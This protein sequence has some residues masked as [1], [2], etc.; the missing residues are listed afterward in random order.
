MLDKKN[1]SINS[2]CS[3]G[4]RLNSFKI[5]FFMIIIIIVILIFII[6]INKGF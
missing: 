2:D 3:L 1:Q 5:Q 6:F 4:Q